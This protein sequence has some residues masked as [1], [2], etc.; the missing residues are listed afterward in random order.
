VNQKLA[1]WMLNKMGH[2]PSMVSTGAEAVEAI[3]TQSFDFVFMEIQM[4]VRQQGC[5]KCLQNLCG[6]A[7]SPMVLQE[8]TWG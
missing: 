6:F 2:L 5:R 3:E 4:P 8:R 7:N 1:A